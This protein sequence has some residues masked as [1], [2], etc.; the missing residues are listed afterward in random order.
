VAEV[1]PEA[2]GDI[3]LNAKNFEAFWKTYTILREGTLILYKRMC[4]RIRMYSD[5]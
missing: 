2:N 4:L 5:V 1:L 3:L